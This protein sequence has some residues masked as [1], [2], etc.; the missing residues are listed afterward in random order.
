[1][2]LTAWID[3]LPEG[4]K[5]KPL[6]SVADY[7]ISNVDKIVDDDEI[8]VRLCNYSD[9]YNNEFITPDMDLMHATATE[10]EIAQYSLLA[11]DV[12]ITKDSES[13]DDIGVPALV[14]G[15]S[16]DLLCG[17]HLALLHPQDHAIIGPFLFRCLQTK[18]VQMQLELAAT[19]VTRFGL[20]KSSIGT[21]L[22]PVPSLKAQ[23]SIVDYIDLEI[24]RLDNLIWTQEGLLELLDEEHHAVIIEAITRGL[25]SNVSL[26]N[27][28][29]S[30][31]GNIPEHWELWRLRHCATVGNGS[32]PSRGNAAYWAEDGTPWLNSSVVNKEEVN[33]AEQFV[34][35]VAIQECHL[36]LVS[37][38]SVLLAIT[39]QGKTRGR[40]VV[41]SIDATVNQHLAYIT[42]KKSLL[43][44]WFL[45][46]T[47]FAAYEFLRSISD[48]TGGTKG[49]LTCRDISDLSVPIPP[50]DEQRAIAAYIGRKYSILKELTGAAERMLSLL[51]E[52]RS[53]LINA[54]VM[55]QIDVSDS[56]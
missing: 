2:T 49:A 13:W 43:N 20:S 35:P 44:P 14:V 27:S 11:N 38:G 22:L 40:S 8:P 3:R 56:S 9:V 54:A 34:T 45:R 47:L 25:N 7:R 33:A 41:L 51:I 46:W 39:G 31:L 6:R 48:D 52:R 55:G 17:Y 5:I 29:A 28:G 12:I 42:P 36:P 32:T 21:V 26:R 10:K 16:S 50:M 15:T 37:K 53:T 30:W 24:A 18:S 19:G 4:W 1:M 23:Q